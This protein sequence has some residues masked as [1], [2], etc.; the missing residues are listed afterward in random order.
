[1]EDVILLEVRHAGLEALEDARLDAGLDGP[2]ELIG[3][4]GEQSN[5][6]SAPGSEL[7]RTASDSHRIS[8]YTGFRVLD[9]YLQSTSRPKIS[10]YSGIR[11]GF[12][13]T[14]HCASRDFHL[15][16][17]FASWSSIYSPLCR[18]RQ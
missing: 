14:I 9:F 16:W 10:I 8:I 5:K 15:L 17:C 3:S 13:F 4:R 6:P 2:L 7:D 12:L 1:M 11:V 18:I